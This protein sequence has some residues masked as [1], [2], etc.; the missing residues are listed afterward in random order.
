[1]N[2]PVG[3]Q[4]EENVLVTGEVAIRFLGVETARVLSTPHLIGF[5]EMASR[6]LIKEYLPPG[7]DSVGT[8]VNIRHLAATPI[9][10]HVRLRA[11][12]VSVDGRRVTCRVEAWDDREKV[13][14][15]THERFVVEIER[16]AFRVFAKAASTQLGEPPG[17]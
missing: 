6:N 11:E 2:I 16:F 13:G 1:M 14:E 9:G 12:I 17:N 3:V 5:L 4:R 10:M 15:G 8:M 7:H